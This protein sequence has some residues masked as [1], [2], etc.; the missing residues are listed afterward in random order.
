MA[1]YAISKRL[2]TPKQMEKFDLDGYAFDAK[3]SEPDRLVFRRKG[4]A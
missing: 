3:A 4:S 1:R 2:T